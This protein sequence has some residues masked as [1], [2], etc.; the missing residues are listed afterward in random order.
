MIGFELVPCHSEEQ[1]H[2]TALCMCLISQG[3]VGSTA[4]TA[5][6]AEGNPEAACQH[7]ACGDGYTGTVSVMELS[8]KI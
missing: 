4:E 8:L 2:V 6:A 7:E 5:L 1:D 3:S